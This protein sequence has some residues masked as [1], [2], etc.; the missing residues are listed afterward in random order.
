LKF[1]DLVE[2][3]VHEPW[4][5]DL[6]PAE[7]V[8]FGADTVGVAP[9]GL[10][11]EAIFCGLALGALISAPVEAEGGE[12]EEVGETRLI[13]LLELAGVV[14]VDGEGADDRAAKL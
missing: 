1:L 8:A 7:G 14:G 12:V 4:R 2:G 13:V 9:L 5:A 6:L 3:L 10:G 11:H